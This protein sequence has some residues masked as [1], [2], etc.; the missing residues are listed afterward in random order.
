M[1]P[2]IIFVLA[3]LLIA[4]VASQQAKA[5]VITIDYNTIA[6]WTVSGHQAALPD[7][8]DGASYLAADPTTVPGGDVY[9]LVAYASDF[10][11]AETTLKYTLLPQMNQ[12]PLSLMRSGKQTALM[13]L[14]HSRS[15]LPAMSSG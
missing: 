5:G 7:T 14:T 8:K 2:R 15:S 13:I 3:M 11:V 6:R 10:G 1:N 9:V 4:C 12:M